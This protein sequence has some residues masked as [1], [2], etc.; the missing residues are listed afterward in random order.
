VSI[1]SSTTISYPNTTGTVTLTTY[2]V[3]AGDEPTIVLEASTVGNTSGPVTAN[4]TLLPPQGT[5]PSVSLATPTG[6][7]SAITSSPLVF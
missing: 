3:S 7:P 5:A 2:S 6:N 4:I 1:P